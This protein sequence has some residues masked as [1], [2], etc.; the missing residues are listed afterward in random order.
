MERTNGVVH[1]LATIEDETTG[2]Q[3]KGR[4]NG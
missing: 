2:Q 4:G 3:A 1:K